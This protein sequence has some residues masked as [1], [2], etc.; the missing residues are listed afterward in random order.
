MEKKS[1]KKLFSSLPFSLFQQ[2]SKQASKKA[3]WNIHAK[4][5]PNRLRNGNF[6]PFFSLQASK[7][8]R[9]EE[10]MLCGTSML[11]F[12]QIGSEITI[13]AHLTRLNNQLTNQPLSKVRIAVTH[14]SNPRPFRTSMPNFSQIC[15]E[16]TILAHLAK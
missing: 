16:M 13:L 7:Q 6:S 2:A 3:I 14:F 15:S 10:R 12:S 9:K 5:Q 11:N 8:A 1:I 4:Y